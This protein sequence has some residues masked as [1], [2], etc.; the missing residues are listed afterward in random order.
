MKASIGF[1]LT[2]SLKL[3]HDRPVEA[4]AMLKKWLAKKGAGLNKKRALMNVLLKRA[5]QFWQ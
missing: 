1:V 2:A 4:L 3:P 5:S